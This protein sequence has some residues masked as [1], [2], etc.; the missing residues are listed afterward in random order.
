MKREEWW[1]NFGMGAEL[2]VAGRFI[3]NG[4]RQF[5]RVDAFWQSGNT[6]E[7]LYNLS[8]GIER[9]QKVAIVLLEHDATKDPKALEESL[10]GHSTLA[11]SDR[12][13][14]SQKQSLSGTQKEFLALLSNFYKNQRYGRFSI[15][16]VPKIE[17]E[18]EALIKYICKHLQMEVPEDLSEFHVRNDD[19]IRK[20][21]GK[22]LKKIVNDLFETISDRAG[23]LNLYT[24]EMHSDSKAGK[25]F[26]CPRLDFVEEDK[27]KRELML[28]LIHPTTSTEQI[29]L[30]RSFE[31]LELDPAM[32]PAYAKYLIDDTAENCSYVRGEVDVLYEDVKDITER[33]EELSLLDDEYIRFEDPDAT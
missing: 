24:D 11:L 5:H 3:Y 25:V 26:L 7:I 13:D 28:F 21:M 30:I 18:H 31:P 17:S 27:I 1:K 23:E 19:R 16:S 8:I 29:R 12:I 32:A 6:F 9:L 33:F 10:K 2:D 20:F 22:V 14:Q 4:V 15:S